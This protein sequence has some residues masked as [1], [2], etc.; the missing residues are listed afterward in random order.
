MADFVRV[1]QTTVSKMS[2]GAAEVIAHLCE[3]DCK[4]YGSVMSW[5][6]TRG[7]CVHVVTCPAC[8]RKFQLDDEDICALERW[9]DQHG[10]T[11]WCG[12]REYA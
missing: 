2:E 6:E 9:T 5:C 4:T 3:S 12:V 8:S 1:D 11:L 7:D 10:A